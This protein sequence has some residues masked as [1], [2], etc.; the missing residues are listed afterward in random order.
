MSCYV[1]VYKDDAGVV[2][3]V[4]KGSGVRFKE[5]TSLARSLNAG[6]RL[7][8]ASHFTRWLAK[9]LRQGRAFHHEIVASGL[10][11]EEAFALECQLIQRHKRLRE[12]GTL[13]YVGWPQSVLEGAQWKRA[14]LVPA[15]PF[16]E[17]PP[18]YSQDNDLS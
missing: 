8:R 13:C 5:H 18:S 17:P 16:A 6:R 7:E 3:Y 4:G 2:R 15:D 14:E 12:G 11:D 9:C 1:Y 10:T